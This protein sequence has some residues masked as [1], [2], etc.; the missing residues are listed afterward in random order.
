MFQ[1]SVVLT[2][3]DFYLSSL[4]S[5]LCYCFSVMYLCFPFLLSFPS[6]FVS[7]FSFLQSS[8]LFT[9]FFFAPVSHFI[10]HTCSKS[11]PVCIK[12]APRHWHESPTA[13][14]SNCLSFWPRRRGV[15]HSAGVLYRPYIECRPRVRRISPFPAVRRL[16]SGHVTSKNKIRKTQPLRL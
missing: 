16:V 3:R 12:A 5:L 9:S 1:N 8:S 13:A 10:L 4:V 2:F 6:S 14:G 11:C 7:F 15:S